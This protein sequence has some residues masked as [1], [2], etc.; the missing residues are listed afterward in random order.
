M[1]CRHQKNLKNLTEYETNI[2]GI[3]T[4]R[5]FLNKVLGKVD[6]TENLVPNTKQFMTNPNAFYQDIY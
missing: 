4:E 6:L 2:K 5:D 1:K 3:I